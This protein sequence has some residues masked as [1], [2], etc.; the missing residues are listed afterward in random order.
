MNDNKSFLD[1]L[2]EQA[3]AKEVTLHLAHI[4]LVLAEISNLEEQIQ[5][6]FE[7]TEREKKILDDWTLRK[8]SKLQDRI[9]WMTKK[10]ESYMKDQG[11][12]VKTIDLPNGKL[13]RRKQPDKMEITD[14]EKFMLNADSQ[15][16]T[17]IPETVRPDI[18]KIM[19]YYK[20]RLILP[21]G[22]RLIIGEEK[23]SIKL[24]NNKE[25]DDGKSSETGIG[26]QQTGTYKAVV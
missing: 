16:L 9:L 25:N 19:S 13:L 17:V 7:Q 5:M 1:E 26:D 18:K 8:N 6:N 12:S 11:D 24:N 23:F 2:L 14:L 21:E 4:D 15:M 3:E 10:L 22:T 20:R